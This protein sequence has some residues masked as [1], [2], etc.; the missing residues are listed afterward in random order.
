MHGSMHL[1]LEQALSRGQS[2][3]MT[4]S[5]RQPEYGSP[6]YSGRHEQ[7]PSR[8]TAFGPHGDGLQGSE[9]GSS[10]VYKFGVRFG[11]VRD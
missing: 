7:E 2:L 9:T 1:F 10:A 6:W 5:G 3:F 11:S 4:H 8:Q